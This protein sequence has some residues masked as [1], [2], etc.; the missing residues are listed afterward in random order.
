[1]FQ[2]AIVRI[3]SKSMINGL[4]SVNLGQPDYQ[5]AIKQHEAYVDALLSCGLEVITLEADENFPDSTFVEDVALCT[6]HCAIITH[7]G[8]ESRRG[9]IEEM[10]E[11]L[12]DEYKNIE[13]IQAPGTVEAGDIM[14]VENHYFIGLSARTNEDGAKQ[15]ISILEKYG[16]TGS[17]VS[18]E[19]V[20]HLKTGLA[21]LENN[22]LVACGEF[23]EKDEFK[24][25]NILEVEQGESYAANCIWVNDTVI[26]PKG[27]PKAK[28]VIGQTGYEIIELD[29]SE[30]QKL[31]G[32]LSC[33][34]L[35]Y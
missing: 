19:E 16:M 8:A 6:P 10:K 29:M 27:F 34:S 9:E 1:M 35:R 25:F 32:G 11:V 14:M 15:M 4:S 31:D 22:Y 18:L 20:L 21:Y 17:L 7:P 28:E 12:K 30:F 2:K 24:K 3:P 26:I 13:F 5:L 33:L 23:L